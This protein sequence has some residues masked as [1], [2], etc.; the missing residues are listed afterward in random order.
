MRSSKAPAGPPPRPRAAVS[1]SG[2]VPAV[3][4]QKPN[5]GNYTGDGPIAQPNIARTG[6]ARGGIAAAPDN[7]RVRF[8]AVVRQ[9]D[10]ASGRAVLMSLRQPDFANEVALI[11]KKYPFKGS[12]A[13]NAE[14]ALI[15]AALA[16]DV[17][18]HS[19]VIEAPPTTL[20]VHY[21]ANTPFSDA[22]NLIINKGKAGNLTVV[23][24]LAGIDDGI[25]LAHKPAHV[26]IPY[27][28]M[29]ARR[30]LLSA[31]SATSPP[32]IGWASRPATPISGSG[33][34]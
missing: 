12:T 24:M 5:L 30:R 9:A 3:V 10:T 34:A 1:P 15:T 2:R 29:P 23:Q 33:M 16:I 21:E 20:N 18:T 31:R 26:D 17:T 8:F 13:I 32:A 28:T 22:I 25:G 4:A 7:G 11:I 19:K 14:L 6:N 27:A